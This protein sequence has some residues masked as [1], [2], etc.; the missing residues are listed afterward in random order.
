MP[1]GGPQLGFDGAD[2]DGVKMSYPSFRFHVKSRKSIWK[3]AASTLS[4]WE[5]VR[6]HCCELVC[7]TPGGT[8]QPVP[9]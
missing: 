2:Y 4:N 1:Q 9:T 3:N 5:C 8:L 6:C 7:H